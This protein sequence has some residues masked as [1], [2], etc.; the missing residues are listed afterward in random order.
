MIGTF[1]AVGGRRLGGHW[2]TLLCAGPGRLPAG[3][4]VT[5]HPPYR[6]AGPGRRGS[7]G[8]A[9]LATS[10]R[11]LISAAA[12]RRASPTTPA[13]PLPATAAPTTASPGRRELR[14]QRTDR[15]G[16]SG[17]RGR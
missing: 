13:S 7:A 12:S 4:T 5:V 3:I 14:S 1:D 11:R 8:D 2:R 15:I 10:P 6:P 17:P 9:M 16:V